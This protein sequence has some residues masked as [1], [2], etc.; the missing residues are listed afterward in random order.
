MGH[1]V[2]WEQTSGLQMA[3]QSVTF[4]QSKKVLLTG[5]HPLQKLS[6]GTPTEQESQWGALQ[7]LLAPAILAAGGRSSSVTATL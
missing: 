6:Q 1:E 7:L 2:M 5:S 3:R 4:F